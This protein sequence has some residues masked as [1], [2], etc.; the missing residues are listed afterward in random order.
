MYYVFIIGMLLSIINF[1]WTTTVFIWK[2]QL[3]GYSGDLNNNCYIILHLC[4]IP[5]V[6]TYCSQGLVM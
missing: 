3:P 1:V 6:F 2:V 4:N 5:W